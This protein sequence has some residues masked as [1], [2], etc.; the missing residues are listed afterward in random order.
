MLPNYNDVKMICKKN[1][2]FKMKTQVEGSTIVAQCT[3][4][5][6]SAGDFFPDIIELEENG[7]TITLYGELDFDGKKL[8]DMSDEEIENL[9]FEFLSKFSF[10]E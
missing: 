3:Y 8:K 1:E 5:L 6:A 2:S 10:S 9:G 4:F 7:E